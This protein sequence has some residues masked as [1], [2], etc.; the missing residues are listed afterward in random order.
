MVVGHRHRGL[1]APTAV[2][3]PGV[4]R[5][6]RRRAPGRSPCGESIG[7]GQIDGYVMV[8]VAIAIWASIRDRWRLVGVALGIAALLK[9]SPVLLIVY[10]VLRGRRQV[11]LPAVASAV[12]VCSPR[13][14]SSAGPPTSSRGRPTWRP[15]CRRARSSSPTSRSRRGPRACSARRRTGSRSTPASGRGASWRWVVAGVGIAAVYFLCRRRSFVPLELGA[16]L[17]VALL[18]GPI[19][20][21]HYPTWALLSVVLLA[22]VG[23]GKHRPWGEIVP[24]GVVMAF[25]ILMM[26]ALDAVSDQPGLRSRHPGSD[27]VGLQDDGHARVP[28]GR[29]LAARPSVRCVTRRGSREG[30]EVGRRR[31]SVD[32]QPTEGV[33]PHG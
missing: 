28:R 10:L 13:P 9:I 4:A 7:L 16:V 32:E 21:E 12:A 33:H 6:L 25:G 8:A 31:L 1:R 23:G 29:A 5:G 20:W 18:A 19:S 15:T 27:H 3:A 14:P 11:L 22:D 24:L 2:A 17:L 26:R 30:D